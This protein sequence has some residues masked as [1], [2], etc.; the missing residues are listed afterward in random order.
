MLAVDAR[1]PPAAAASRELASATPGAR[2][3]AVQAARPGPVPAARGPGRRSRLARRL[4]RGCATWLEI[5]GYD[6]VE[7]GVPEG[8]EI[9]RGLNAALAAKLDGEPHGREQELRV[10]LEAGGEEG[11]RGPV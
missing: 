10:A 5:D 3:P 9:G 1:D 4:R 2:R 7:A 8:P 11:D 6:L